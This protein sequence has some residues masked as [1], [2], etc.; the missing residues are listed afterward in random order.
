VG[1]VPPISGSYAQGTT[2]QIWHASHAQ[3]LIARAQVGDHYALYFGAGLQVADR[4]LHER[5]ASVGVRNPPDSK[6]WRVSAPKGVT[7]EALVV[8]FPTPMNYPLLQRMLHVSGAHGSVAGTISVD[9]Q[10]T[11]WRFTPQD[12]WKAGEYQVIVDT[13]LED[14]AGNHIG[15]AFDIDVFERVTEHITANTIFLPFVVR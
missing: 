7:S 3:G 2:L 5:R 9:K 14:L 13:G 6:Q 10:E 4:D 8:S 1:D 11:Q 12:P 15:H